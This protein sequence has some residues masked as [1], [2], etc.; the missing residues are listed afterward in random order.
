[1]NRK[2]VSPI[3]LA[4]ITTIAIVP[5]LPIAKVNAQTPTLFVDPGL[6]SGDIG[7]TFDIYVMMSDVSNLLAYDVTLEYNTAALSYVNVDF[8]DGACPYGVCTVFVGMSHF[9]IV[10]S[11][12][13]ATGTIRTA[14]TLLGGITKNVGAPEPV[15]IVTFSVDNS[16]D[17]FFDITNDQIVVKVGPSPAFLP[18]DT[19]DGEFLSPPVVAMHRWDVSVAPSDR[20]RFLSRGE[21]SVTLVGTMRMHNLATRGGYGFIIFDIVDPTGNTF[22]VMSN[23]AFVNPGEIVNVYATFT[24]AGIMGRYELFGTIYRGPTETFFVPGEFTSGLHFFVHF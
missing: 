12:N 4:L 14:Q 9:S 5:A 3:L 24:Y 19:V 18:H 13:D 6:V 7:Q 17:S 10:E 16:L 8:D 23:V 2:V 20:Q 22:S 1:M 15:L 21:L 11:A